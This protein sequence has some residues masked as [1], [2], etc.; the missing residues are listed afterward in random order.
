MESFDILFPLNLSPLTYFVPEDLKGSVKPGQLVRAEIRSTEKVG[1]VLGRSSAHGIKPISGICTTEPLVSESLLGLINWMSDYYM[2]NKGLVLKTM[3]PREFYDVVSEG[4]DIPKCSKSEKRGQYQSLLFHVYQGSDEILL[5]ND[6][7]KNEKNIIILCPERSYLETVSKR[8]IP[9]LGER[10]C[11][12]HGDLSKR[13]RIQSYRQIISGQSDIVIGTRIAIFAPLKDVSLIVVLKEGDAS[14]KNIQGMRFHGRDVAVKRGYLEKAKV[15]MSSSA[16]SV[17]SFYNAI[18]GKYKL[19]SYGGHSKG[20]RIEIVDMNRSPKVSPYISKRAIDVSRSCLKSAGNLLFLVN[21]KGYSLIR[22]RDC[23]H[24]EGCRMCKVPLVYH[25]D[26]NI[27]L[28]HYCGTSIETTDLCP[29]CGGA[30]LEAVGAGTQ[31]IVSEIKGYLNTD[32]LRLEKGLKIEGVKARFE[33]MREGVVIVSTGIIKRFQ[34]EGRFKACIFINPDLYLQFPDFRSGERLFNELQNIREW[35]EP[36]GL[37]LI[38]TRFPENHVYRAFRKRSIL[39]FYDTELSLRR[40]LLYPPFSKFAAVTIT[41]EKEDT[42]VI[43]E[44]L[45]SS[46]VKE[47]IDGCFRD[48]LPFPRVKGRLRK[49]SSW[50][51]IFKSSSQKR[52]REGIQELLLKTEGKKGIKIV[53]D[54]DPVSLLSE[55][56]AWH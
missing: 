8:L 41:C 55:A 28:C 15:I 56:F 23:D 44:I 9:T 2:V 21:R 51:V 46:P 18:R 6:L 27:L 22:C 19:V 3:Y 16:P 36:G 40:S 13:E 29:A 17:E 49:K 20:P 32:P 54:V 12:L 45:N 50:R 26:R 42:Q 48:L 10:L 53:V 11:L 30:T 24:I 31:R 33:G 37:V 38:Q 52:L 47:F 25:R 14:Y 7:I 5:L 4:M 43:E 1:L 35:V 39:E 34:L